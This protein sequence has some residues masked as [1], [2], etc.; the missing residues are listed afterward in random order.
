M[1]SFHAMAFTLWRV[2]VSPHLVLNISVSEVSVFMMV[3]IQKA[4]ADCQI[5]FTPL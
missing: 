1:F 2:V 5:V 3:A 4:W